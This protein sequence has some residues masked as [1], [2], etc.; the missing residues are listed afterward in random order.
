MLTRTVRRAS[1]LLI[2]L[3]IVGGLA[4]CAAPDASSTASGADTAS[5]TH[6]DD[7]PARDVILITVDTL[8]WDALGFADGPA[9][10]RASTPVLD[11][12][13]AAGTIYRD[14]YA[15]NVVTLPSHANLLTGRYPYDHGVRE[16]SGFVL[17]DDVPTLATLLGDA[18]FATGAFVAAFPLD[19]RFGLARGFA[20]YDDAVAAG[21]DDAFAIPERRGDAV[22]APALAWWQAE[23]A[24]RRFLWVHLYDPHAP[25]AAEPRFAAQ[26]PDQ[27]YLG[28]VAAVDA[29]LA[30]LLTPLLDAGAR[31]AIVVVTADHG[32]ALGEHGEMTHGLFAYQPTLKVPLVVWG[33]RIAAGAVDAAPAAHVDLLPT[34]LDATGLDD[35]LPADLP[36]RSL[37]DAAARASAAERPIYFEALSAYYNRG[38]APLRGVVRDRHKAI[39]VPLIE[40]YDLVDDPAESRN[41]VDDQRRR[42]N[43]LRADL[44]GPAWPPAAADAA[45]QLDPEAAAQLRALGYLSAD[46]AA[47]DRAFTP[48]DDPKRLVVL[49]RQLHEAVDS[50]T[51]GQYDAAIATLQ[52][53]VAA[54]PSMAVGHMHLA[55]SLRAADR[56]GE[57]IAVL[58]R[59]LA[60]GVDDVALARQLGL[61]L[62]EAGRGSEAIDVLAPLAAGG[63]SDPESLA[64]LGNAYYAAGRL[65]EAREAYERVLAE[66][67]DD[68]QALEGLG[69]VALASRRPDIA[70]GVLERAVARHPARAMAWN[71]LGVARYQLGDPPAALDAWA[72]AVALDPTLDQAL[73]NLGVQ[74]ARHGRPDVAREAL[75]RFLQRVP[76]EGAS[77]QIARDRATARDILRRL[78]E[79]V[80]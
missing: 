61:T 44:A 65:R 38:W 35:R 28:E 11:R 70:R 13:A 15:H 55:M 69:A 27:P 45:N 39:D 59:A 64:A 62:A 5:P 26:H 68:P 77:P 71:S 76:A 29:Y 24:R 12:L 6:P 36:G 72:R 47:P 18:G 3:L 16:N 9:E 10:R 4:G 66:D 31:D 37:R 58:E 2:A 43:A 78:G 7:P 8:R 57:A 74:G 60:D 80:P 46:G 17:R 32:E 23:R 22:V 50:F 30:P 51:R 49:D 20:T 14:A 25:Y 19:R 54:R 1:C 42:L 41:R 73:F 34:L 52:D 63:A 53:V 21:R 79:E 56:G 75:R 48:D 33:A 40:L 67:D